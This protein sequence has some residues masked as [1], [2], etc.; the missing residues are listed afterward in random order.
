MIE[1]SVSIS[2]A[3]LEAIVSQAN[4]LAN[5]KV[6]FMILFLFFLFF[7]ISICDL[8]FRRVDQIFLQSQKPFFFFF[9]PL[10]CLYDTI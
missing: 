6:D 1:L 8:D 10:S 2:S 9:F 5:I 7:Y 3:P 4:S